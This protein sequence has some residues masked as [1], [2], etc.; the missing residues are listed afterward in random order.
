[1]S[2]STPSH[3][4]LLRF[5]CLI[6]PVTDDCC[7][8]TNHL[9]GK[10]VRLIIWSLFVISDFLSRTVHPRLIVWSIT[11][12]FFFSFPHPPSLFF[13]F[14][15]SVFKVDMVLGYPHC[16]CR[17]L[18]ELLGHDSIERTWSHILQMHLRAGISS[19]SKHPFRMLT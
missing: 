10:S 4:H 6:F 5:D 2:T 16:T 3:H 11:K 14:L 13:L 17:Y 12:Q 7:N 19:P 1:M 15:G 9:L 8:H 18:L